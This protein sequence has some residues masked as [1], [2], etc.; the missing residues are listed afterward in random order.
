LKRYTLESKIHYAVLILFSYGDAVIANCRFTVKLKT[1]KQYYFVNRAHERAV[2]HHFFGQLL[3]SAEAV[4][5]KFWILKG[6]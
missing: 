1:L 6:H 2:P 4:F 5:A 3:A